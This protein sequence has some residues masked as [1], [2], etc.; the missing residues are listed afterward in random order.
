MGRQSQRDSRPKSSSRRK[1]NGLAYLFCS[2]SAEKS[3]HK[4]PHSPPPVGGSNSV[5]GFVKVTADA[6]AP[7]KAQVT[8]G[9]KGLHKAT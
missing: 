4:K 7:I 6:A 9:M 5:M 3:E 8:R 1:G 2:K